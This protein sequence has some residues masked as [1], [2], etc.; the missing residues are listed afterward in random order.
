MTALSFKNYG[1]LKTSCL[2]L[3]II[4]LI[5]PRGEMKVDFQRKVQQEF[6]G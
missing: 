2:K 6:L 5:F 4:V 1:W 3:M